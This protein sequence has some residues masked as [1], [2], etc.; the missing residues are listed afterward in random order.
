MLDV[1]D[2]DADDD[3]KLCS[4]YDNNHNIIND[5]I[6]EYDKN[7]LIISS[8]LW[9]S[10]YSNNSYI[11]HIVDIIIPLSFV[12]LIYHLFDW[13]KYSIHLFKS[14]LFWYTGQSLHISSVGS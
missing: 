9:T 14:P 12:A 13:L 1:V 7:I 10:Y 3:S 4:W 6:N 11:M 8:I 2:Y 5:N